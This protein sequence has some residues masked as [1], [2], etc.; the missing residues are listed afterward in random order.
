MNNRIQFNE[1]TGMFDWTCPHCATEKHSLTL[2]LDS[3]GLIFCDTCKG[4]LELAL[5]FVPKSRHF[6]S[7]DEGRAAI[8][9][10]A[11]TDPSMRIT[12]PTLDLCALR[13]K[14]DDLA[15]AFAEMQKE[16]LNLHE[17]MDGDA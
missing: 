3:P 5:S 12:D 4:E 1:N 15:V 13:R 14:I 7:I 9:E 2:P 11:P 17:R 16:M 6:E 8:R 10:G